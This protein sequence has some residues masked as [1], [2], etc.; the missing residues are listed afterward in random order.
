MQ[1]NKSWRAIRRALLAATA[2]TGLPLGGAWA[3]D[4]KWGAWIDAGGKIGS[5]RDIR[6]PGD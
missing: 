5:K 4:A 6:K 2:L 3:D 1:R